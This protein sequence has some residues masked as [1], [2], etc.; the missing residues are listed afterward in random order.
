[1]DKTDKDW[2]I[3][4]YSNTCGLTFKHKSVLFRRKSEFQDVKII[5]S[6]DYG[7]IL[8]LDDFVYRTEWFGQVIP[9]MIVHTSILTGKTK[10]NVLLV[11]GGDGWSLA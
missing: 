11:G 4:Y 3:D 10:R 8:L 2:F 5:D 1:M 7:K 6:E 9:E